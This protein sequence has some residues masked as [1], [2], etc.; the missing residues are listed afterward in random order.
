MIITRSPLR[1]SL[2]GGGT[3]LP[4]YY[5]DHTGFL[6]A[7]A[8]DRHVHIV[9]NRTILPE[10]ILK[11][12]QTERVT[13]VGAIQHPLVREAMRLVG[14]PADGLEIAA[15]ADI[16]AGTGL[17]SSG[18]FCTALLR[19]LHALRNGNPSAAELAEQACHI[20][21]DRLREPVGK[22]DQFI[23]AVGGV[24]CFRFHPDGHVE[25]W[26][27]R[28]S[29]DTLRRLERNLVLYF[30]GYTRSASEVLREQDTKTKAA[31]QSMID[32]L[33]FIKDLGLKSKEALE[34]GDLR[35]FAEL[36][37]VHWRSK[38][39]R[40]GN[41]SNSRIDEWYD[42]G[43]K[44]GGLGGKLIGAGGGG[45]L[46]F[47]TEDAEQLTDT[48]TEAGLQQVPFR[49]DFEGTR[50]VSGATPSPALRPAVRRAA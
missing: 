39:K 46:M 19:G 18:S 41:M 50:I 5:R 38:K 15:M 32:N 23:A 6:V 17:G 21:I 12:S 49:F 40:S 10:M 37:N 42:L 13:D 4:S 36:M 25:Y 20:E 43:L 31:D 28:A 45:F 22:Q 47:Y 16:P 8:I 14:I 34:G 48:M 7:A 11:Y 30:T 35:A 1:I 24:T 26:P 33:H 9:I 2:G 29:S 27:L 44:H 3:D